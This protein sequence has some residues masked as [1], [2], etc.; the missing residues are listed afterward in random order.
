MAN[1]NHRNTKV[2]NYDVL[3][4]YFR[5]YSNFILDS[6]NL[7]TITAMII[8]FICALLLYILIKRF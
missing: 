4:N 5:S 2:S 8:S 7:L 3:I 6:E 1:G